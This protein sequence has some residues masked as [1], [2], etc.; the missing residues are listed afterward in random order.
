MQV[1][2]EFLSFDGVLRLRSIA[3]LHARL[4]QAMSEHTNV[5]IDCANAESIDASFIQLLL[6]ARRSAKRDGVSLDIAIAPDGALHRA[7]ARC[8]LTPDALSGPAAP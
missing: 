2:P 3:T 1:E 4:L 8:G 7:I 5:L 6:S